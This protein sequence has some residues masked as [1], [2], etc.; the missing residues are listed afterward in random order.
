MTMW[1]TSEI[2]IL[3]EHWAHL[4]AS[5]V[6]ADLL[7]RRTSQA[8]DQKASKLGLVKDG[9]IQSLRA[10]RKAEM[11]KHR[12]KN[13]TGRDLSEENL[14]KLATQYKTRQHFK[15][16]DPSAYTTARQR[17]CLDDICKHMTDDYINWPQAMLFEIIKSIFP[18][19]VVR[20][21]DRTIIRPKE[22]DVFV[23]DHM[24][25]F[26]YDG[27]YFHNDLAID[28]AKDEICQLVGIKLYRIK[29]INKHKP[30][31]DIVQQL[32]S[33]GFDVTNL[34][35]TD[36]TNKVMAKHMHDDQIKSIIDKYEIYS[37]F[38]KAEKTLVRQLSKLG[39]LNKYTAGLMRSHLPRP[40]EQEVVTFLKNA[41][42]KK[43]IIEN[44]R[45]YNFI[46]RHASPQI[47]AQYRALSDGRTIS[48]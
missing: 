11:L 35:K 16:L 24:V 29:E 37:D 22:I 27:Q 38:I 6:L 26:E 25:G 4:D 10:D 34:V 8:I 9:L 19:S 40:L 30:F 21:N 47:R 39:L 1:S 44:S 5:S 33:Y 42:C 17:G 2:A 48:S 41:K 36:I 7:G 31:E 13:I 20:Y 15:R 3:E 43:D 32:M 14:R 45:I 46:N 12:N 23:Q 28:K 18:R